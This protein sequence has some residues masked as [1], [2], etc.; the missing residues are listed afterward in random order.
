[1][2]M[3]EFSLKEHERNQEDE[4]DDDKWLEEQ[5]EENDEEEEQEEKQ[6]K[7]T[8]IVRPEEQEEEK[9]EELEETKKEE[10][11]EE[12]KDWVLDNYLL[13]SEGINWKRL[14]KVI[15]RQ[16]VLDSEGNK[17][18]NADGIFVFKEVDQ[19]LT[20]KAKAFCLLLKILSDLTEKLCVDIL[21]STHYG[22]TGDRTCKWCFDHW[23][24]QDYRFIALPNTETNLEKWQTV[25]SQTQRRL[26]MLWNEKPEQRGWMN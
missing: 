5:Q 2:N 19:K 14:P 13:V 12:A 3:E 23:M 8:G 7:T 24:G 18:R 25:Y 4:E 10:E 15:E 1:M 9:E 11:Q 16:H 22:E 17:V 20:N 6:D 21:E 26:P